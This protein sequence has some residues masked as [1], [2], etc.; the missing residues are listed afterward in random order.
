MFFF[1]Q[2][3]CKNSTWLPYVVDDGRDVAFFIIG[4]STYIGQWRQNSRQAERS[5]QVAV[6][7]EV[8]QVAEAAFGLEKD[9]GQRWPG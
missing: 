6:V 1:Q 4:N 8:Q 2:Y 7:E 9:E 5:R 3:F